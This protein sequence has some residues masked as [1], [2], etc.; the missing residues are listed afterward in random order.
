MV[1]LLVRG[2]PELGILLEQ[3]Q[4]LALVLG[5][6]P[7]RRCRVVGVDVSA[8]GLRFAKKPLLPSSHEL[9]VLLLVLLAGGKEECGCRSRGEG[10]LLAEGRCG[11]LAH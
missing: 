5:R 2:E 9:L 4:L 3:L 7:H 1:C 11:P 6:Y 8:D 10:A